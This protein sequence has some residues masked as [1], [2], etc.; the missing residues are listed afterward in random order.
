MSHTSMPT[1]TV[2]LSFLICSF[3]EWK[4]C[5]CPAMLP[6]RHTAMLPF[7]YLPISSHIFPHSNQFTP[8]PGPPGPPGS[9]RAPIQAISPLHLAGVLRSSPP[10]APP[11]RC[12][13]AATG[14]SRSPRPRGGATLSPPPKKCHAPPGDQTGWGKLGEENGLWIGYGWWR[15]S[16]RYW[17][18]L[19]HW[20]CSILNVWS[21]VWD[22]L[23]YFEH[24]VC[25]L[26]ETW[27]LGVGGE[28]NGDGKNM[29]EPLAHPH[30]TVSKQRFPL[31][32]MHSWICGPFEER[33]KQ[34]WLQTCSL[35]PQAKPWTT[36]SHQG[37]IEKR[38]PESLTWYPGI[39]LLISANLSI[40]IHPLILNV[41]PQLVALRA[42]LAPLL[43][44][45][46][47]RSR[48]ELHA[49]LGGVISLLHFETPKKDGIWYNPILWSFG[50]VAHTYIHIYI[51]IYTHNYIYNYIYTHNYI[52]IY[53]ITILLL[54]GD[55]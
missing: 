47:A 2:S 22:G 3:L 30:T 32:G 1:W 50:V 36:P 44:R 39:I 49:G 34:S 17:M 4:N 21:M 33:L 51:Y 40:S 48:D 6:C 43:S 55:Y 53:F 37:L 12:W 54:F 46:A 42:P 8:F 20:K 18:L 11:G 15:G 38:G 13:P 19:A 16:W 10:A 35:N 9:P 25:R 29:E 27:G 28:R 5:E 23:R 26:C 24:P 52:Y 45:F 7:R 41:S 14:R 31:E